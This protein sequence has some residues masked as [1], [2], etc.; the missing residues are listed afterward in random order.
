M[1]S[2]SLKDVN[3]LI[4]GLGSYEVKVSFQT[5]CSGTNQLSFLNTMLG[6]AL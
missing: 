1:R 3:D 2:P 4:K 5:G 6:G